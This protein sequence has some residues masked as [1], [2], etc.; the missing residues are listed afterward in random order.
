MI[1]INIQA[2]CVSTWKT[3]FSVLAELSMFISYYFG[4]YTHTRNILRMGGI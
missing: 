3:A 1:D 4:N 2:K